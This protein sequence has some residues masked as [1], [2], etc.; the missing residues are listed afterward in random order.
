M[1]L[2]RVAFA[3]A[4]VVHALFVTEKTTC[5]GPLK[6]KLDGEACGSF[7]LDLCLSSV[8]VVVEYK[9][10]TLMNDTIS[11]RIRKCHETDFPGCKECVGFS[12]FI[13]TPTFGRICGALI[14]ECNGFDIGSYELKCIELGRECKATSC[15]E[16]ND[17][18]GCGWCEINQ[19]CLAENA[20]HDDLFKPDD[21][22]YCQECKNGEFYVESSTCPGLP[23][24][25]EGVFNKKTWFATFII[26]FCSVITLCVV[27]LMSYKYFTRQQSQLGYFTLTSDMREALVGRPTDN[28]EP[29]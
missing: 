15:V 26:V 23:T 12:E 27:I 21:Q 9:N 5:I 10:R 19:K 1:V 13:I 16:C 7:K 3:F 25:H 4:G 8:D 18:H 24:A 20:G 11:N 17:N 29:L 14:M 2:S 6:D 28:L 22:P